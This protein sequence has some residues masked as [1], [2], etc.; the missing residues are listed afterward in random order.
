MIAAAAKE[1]DGYDNKEEEKLEEEVEEAEVDLFF[2]VIEGIKTVM[3]QIM[4]DDEIP[5]IDIPLEVRNSRI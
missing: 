3:K 2:P 4:K 1:D 5:I